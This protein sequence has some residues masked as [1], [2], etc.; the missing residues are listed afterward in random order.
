MSLREL[1]AQ[2]GVSGMAPYRH[3]EDK[4]ALMQ[5][6]AQRGF[7]LFAQEPRGWP[8]QARP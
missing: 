5:A 4:A 1:A 6:A 7:A 3:F 8:G 2:A